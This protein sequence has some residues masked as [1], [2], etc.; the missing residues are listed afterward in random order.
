VDRGIHRGIL[1]REVDL[2]GGS[3]GVCRTDGQKSTW[4]VSV[5]S[6][7]HAGNASDSA[8]YIPFF[9]L[10]RGAPV[11]RMPSMEKIALII[12]GVP[13]NGK[14]GVVVGCNFSVTAMTKDGIPLPIQVRVLDTSGKEVGAKTGALLD[15]GFG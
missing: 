14:L 3:L 13:S 4:Q 9:S 10:D 11:E 8:P 5:D 1:G 2:V 7:T 15:F 6:W 12:M